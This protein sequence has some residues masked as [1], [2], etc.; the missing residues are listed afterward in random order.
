MKELQKVGACEACHHPQRRLIDQ[1]IAN[2]QPNA[3]I[4][5]IYPLPEQSLYTHRW[6][7]VPLSMASALADPQGLLV[8]AQLAYQKIQYWEDICEKQGIKGAARGLKAAELRMK[9]IETMLRLMEEE[10]AHKIAHDWERI[11]RVLMQVFAKYPEARIEFEH[12]L[13]E[14]GE[15]GVMLAEKA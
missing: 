13:Q 15:S 1:M 3:I 8:K 7:H 10:S 4:L 14:S 5:E 6:E 2:G 9:H 11:K 12:L